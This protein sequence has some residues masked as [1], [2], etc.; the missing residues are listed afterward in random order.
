LGQF[1]WLAAPMGLQGAPASFSRLMDKVLLDVDCA[2]A[3][4]DDCLVHSKTWAGHLEDVDLV[5]SRFAQAGLKLNLPKCLVFRTEVPYL[6]HTL[7]VDGVSPGKDKMEALREAE[8]PRDI[9]SLRSYLGLA[10]YMRKW[11]SNFSEKA[12]PLHA[13]TRSTS[14]WK[15]GQLPAEAQAAFELLQKEITTAPTLAR[16]NERGTF[17]LF[18]AHMMKAWKE[19]S[20]HASYK[21]RMASSGQWLL[22]LAY[23]RPRSAITQHSCW[24]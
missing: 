17:H 11:V 12:A 4:L 21:I 16:P 5:F 2:V 6:G 23:F 13:L 24:S 3:F 9:T 14:L 19:G 22:H 20:G 8:P 18:A 10:N 7:S 15:K 1:Q